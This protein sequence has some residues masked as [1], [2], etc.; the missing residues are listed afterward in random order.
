MM[1]KKKAERRAFSKRA[2]SLLS[3]PPHDL[4]TKLPTLFTERKPVLGQ[5]A[6]P[7]RCSLVDSIAH[8]VRLEEQ[9]QDLEQQASAQHERQQN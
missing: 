6:T 5:E 4:R 9:P 8:I 7:P 2:R 1:K 3:P